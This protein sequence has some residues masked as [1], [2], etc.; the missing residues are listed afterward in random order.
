MSDPDRRVTPQFLDVV[1]VFWESET[2]LHGYEVKKRTKRTGPT[3][4]NALDKLRNL[5]WITE[6]GQEAVSGRPQRT[7]FVLTPQGRSAAL[8][9]LIERGRIKG[10]PKPVIASGPG[11]DL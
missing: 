1:E 4:Y 8:H 9:L 10:T 2:G 6:V 3:V 7:V 11:G 5:G